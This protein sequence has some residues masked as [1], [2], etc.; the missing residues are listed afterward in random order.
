MEQKQNCSKELNIAFAISSGF[1]ER[2]L[3]SVKLMKDKL[4]L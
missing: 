1:D 4:N 2:I 3:I